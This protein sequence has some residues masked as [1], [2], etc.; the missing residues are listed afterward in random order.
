[1]SV[2]EKRKETVWR[3]VE[4]SREICRQKRHERRDNVVRLSSFVEIND[5]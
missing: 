2:V 1:L 5:L 4:S 3:I